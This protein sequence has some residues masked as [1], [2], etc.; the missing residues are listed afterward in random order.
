MKI[1]LF[2][3][4]QKGTINFKPLLISFPVLK[5][6]A[7]LL[8]NKLFHLSASVIS[9]YCLF[10][11]YMG[12]YADTYMLINKRKCVVVWNKVVYIMKV[13]VKK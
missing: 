8:V 13:A 1:P 2:D 12:D 10:L 5:S 3:F 9:K 11:L 4:C 6:S 7:L